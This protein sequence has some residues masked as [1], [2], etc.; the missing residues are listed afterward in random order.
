M[1]ILGATTLYFL[2]LV[3]PI[4]VAPEYSLGNACFPSLYRGAKGIE[5]TIRN[6]TAA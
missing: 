2:L 4:V 6:M 5:L 1:N 3:F